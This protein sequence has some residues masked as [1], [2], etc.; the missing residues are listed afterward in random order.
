MS[1][2][3]VK[4]ALSVVLLAVVASSLVGCGGN[5]VAEVARN[6]AQE[7]FLKD[8]TAPKNASGQAM[9]R[10][11]A[12]AYWA[13]VTSQLASCESVAKKDKVGHT[14]IT[15]SVDKFNYVLANGDKPECQ[16]PQPY[17]TVVK[18]MVKA[19]DY[20]IKQ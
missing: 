18:N 12:V 3:F 14:L 7:M 9:T 8:P 6:T 10:P 1:S 4:F 13:T 19:G 17:S 5:N 20:V 11:E 2:K 16:L 15:V